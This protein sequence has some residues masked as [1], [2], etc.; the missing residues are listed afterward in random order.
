MSQADGSQLN[1]TADKAVAQFQAIDEK[2]NAMRTQV[3][4]DPDSLGDKLLKFAIPSLAGLVF[5]RIFKSVW[6]KNVS[7]SRGGIE[8]N[9]SGEQQE[10]FIASIVFA[11]LSAAFAAVV[12]QVSNKGSQALVDRLHSRK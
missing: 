8:G 5:G 6:D 3:R 11:G 10:G 7:R 4:M 2:V 9:D 12:S 1:A